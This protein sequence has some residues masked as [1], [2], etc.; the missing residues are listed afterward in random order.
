MN[1]YISPLQIITQPH[2]RMDEVMQAQKV[3]EGGANWLQLRIKGERQQQWEQIGRDVLAVVRQ[4]NATMIL[5]DNPELAARIGADG[6]HLGKQDMSPR[7]ARNIVGDQAIIGGTANTFDDILRLA[8]AGVDY[9][10]LGPFR[11]TTTKQ[12]LSPVLGLE[13]YRTI[14]HSMQ[15]RNI[16]IPLVAIG[17]IT[18]SDFTDILST[19]VFGIA[20]SGE[21]INDDQPASKCQTLIKKLSEQ[22]GD[23]IWTR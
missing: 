21:I 6:V 2:P 13:G 1:K 19:G 12:N 14:I 16:D 23:Q 17:G 10:G 15:Q 3:F 18:S 8:D 11:F 5:N 7:D 4:Y 22:K 9:I 20:L